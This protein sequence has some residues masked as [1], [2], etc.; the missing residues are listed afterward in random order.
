MKNPDIQICALIEPKT[1]EIDPDLIQDILSVVTIYKYHKQKQKSGE[2]TI[3][4]TRNKR[5]VQTKRDSMK[6]KNV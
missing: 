3:I 1:N 5:L 2:N 4:D 6:S